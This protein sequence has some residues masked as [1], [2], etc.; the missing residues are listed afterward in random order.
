MKR[1]RVLVIAAIVA[2][3]G[4]SARAVE[5]HVFAA[6]SLSDALTEL[7]PRYKA[8]TGDTLVFNFGGSGTLARQIEEGAPADVF[9]SADELRANLLQ[10][11]GLLEPATRRN[12]VAN[13]LVVVVPADAPA[14][15]LASFKD[16]ESRRF[17]RI[18][19]GDPDVVPAGTYAREVLRKAGVW[20]AVR[21][22]LVPLEN[23]RAVLAA[24]DSDNAD[25]GFVYATDA[26]IARH[27]RV[28]FETP[29][30]LA[31]RIEYP[32]AV[33]KGAA[34]AERGRALVKFLAGKTARAVF[35][36]YG[37]KM[38]SVR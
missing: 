1:L 35:V 11:K 33:V 16:L 31:P 20:E 32:M 6:A 13:V 7:A 22:K 17:K 38:P 29:E 18:A 23:V 30:A 34:Q 10:S 14:G 9:I 21:G 15:G 26:A 19:I 25:A 24:V 4:I 12:L 37:F 2:A 8:L 27:A 3:L 28:A 5:I 36:K